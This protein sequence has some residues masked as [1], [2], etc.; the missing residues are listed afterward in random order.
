MFMSK[1]PI[2]N[3][4]DEDFIFRNAKDTWLKPDNT[5]DP[6][7]FW[8]FES[9]GIETSVIWDKYCSGPFG[10]KSMAKEPERYGVFKL[11]AGIVRKVENQTVEHKPTTNR[12]H[13][14]IN[15]EKNEEILFRLLEISEL[16]IA[17]PP[18]KPAIR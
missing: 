15:G 2:E 12:A 4:P 8:D 9:N 16:V 10:A 13:S 18:Y 1:W 3:I 6:Y 7:V 17:I 5:V 11:N 14:L